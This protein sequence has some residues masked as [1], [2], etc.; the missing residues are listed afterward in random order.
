MT[1]T[2]AHVLFIGFEVLVVISIVGCILF[3][4]VFVRAMRIISNIKEHI[5]IPKRRG[6]N[7]E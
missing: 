5:I 4:V 1:E 7:D 2:V 6:E 3:A